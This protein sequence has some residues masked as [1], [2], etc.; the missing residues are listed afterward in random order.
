MFESVFA[1]EGPDLFNFRFLVVQRQLIGSI[2]K[3]CAREYLFHAHSVPDIVVVS[4]IRVLTEMLSDIVMVTLL[5][6]DTKWK[7]FI[8]TVRW[9]I[10]EDHGLKHGYIAELMVLILQDLH[11]FARHVRFPNRAKF[12]HCQKIDKKLQF[13]SQLLLNLILLAFVLKIDNS[14]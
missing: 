13:C 1:Q 7:K 12:D 9:W 2:E 11:V 6:R 4:I 5:H 3:L 14:S 8:S 10:V